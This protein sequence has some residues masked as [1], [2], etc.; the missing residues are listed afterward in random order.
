MSSVL[1]LTDHKVI[2]RIHGVKGVRRFTWPPPG[3]IPFAW[4]CYATHPCSGWAPFKSDEIQSHSI[5]PISGWPNHP[6][7]TPP[8]T[9]DPWTDWAFDRMKFMWGWQDVPHNYPAQE[10]RNTED[11]Y[12]ESIFTLR[13]QSDDV[14]SLNAGTILKRH[15]KRHKHTNAVWY[16]ALQTSTDDGENWSDLWHWEISESGTITTSGDFPWPASPQENEFMVPAYT[17]TWFAGLVTELSEDPLLYG[18]TYWDLTASAT[19]TT[20]LV[21]HKRVWQDVTP[22]Y[23]EAATV[24]TTA[25][26]TM[27]NDVGEPWSVDLARQACDELSALVHFEQGNREYPSGG[28]GTAMD[29]SPPTP[30][31]Q[32][33]TLAW[34]APDGEAEPVLPLRVQYTF[35]YPEA[36][37][38]E[39]LPNGNFAWGGTAVM[40]TAEGD[41]TPVAANWLVTGLYAG[42]GLVAQMK[43][44]IG[45]P[46]IP[47]SY[48]RLSRPEIPSFPATNG[49]PSP[50]PEDV[51]TDNG[52]EAVPGTPMWLGS[53]GSGRTYFQVPA[54][55]Q[56]IEIARPFP[57]QIDIDGTRIDT[58]GRAID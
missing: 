25:T 5:W 36:T 40:P 17:E 41:I 10:F 34:L 54:P 55:W 23:A 48:T 45:L 22:P 56:G 29:P 21:E 52:G 3:E 43:T 30:Y 1:S 12:L 46:D 27:L 16:D 32:R 53:V 7:D 28:G 31:G 49:P 37:G 57:S 13:V 11:R 4:I 14:A 8:Y 2:R 50:D 33:I 58:D 47:G 38:A 18:Y 35:A 39:F 26:F 42:C 9:P 51:T 44:M 6:E 19:A 24:N 20:S 15:T